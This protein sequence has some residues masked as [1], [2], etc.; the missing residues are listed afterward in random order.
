M[1][2]SEL[3]RLA[4]ALLEADRTHQPTTR[5]STL[6]PD[7]TVDDAYRIALAVVEARVN[8]GTRIKGHKIGLTSKAMQRAVGIDEPDYGHLL[9]DMFVDEGAVVPHERLFSPLAEAE[10]AFVLG[11]ALTGPG[12]NAADVIRA[13]DFVLPCIEVVDSRFVRE[14]RGTLVDTIADNAS[15][16]LVV[17]GGNPA[18][19]TD[20]DIRRVGVSVA[21]NGVVEETGVAS[22]VMGNPITAV[23]WLANKLSHFGVA[24]EAGQVILSGS[25]TRL[26]RFGPGDVV[27]ATFDPLGEVV[28][29]VSAADSADRS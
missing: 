28:V 24:L 22:A 4:D 10:L 5:V 8:T 9:D 7:A 3:R 12:V 17:L 1:R 25:F 11:D 23:A 13:T 14:G 16:G 19:L 15:S 21:R 26:V 27:S 6:A 20:L 18:R 2:E 29:S